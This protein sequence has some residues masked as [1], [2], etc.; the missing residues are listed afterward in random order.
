MNMFALEG[1]IFPLQQTTPDVGELSG[2]FVTLG[3]IQKDAVSR[4]LLRIAA[5]HQVKQR[6]SVR[7]AVE[8]GGLAGGYRR[9][10]HARAQGHQELQALGH[11]DHRRR[12]QPCILTGASGRDQ[13]PGKANPICGLGD[14]LEISMIHRACALVGTQIMTITVGR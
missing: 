14:L 11:R 1:H 12:H 9:R 5:G 7:Q 3:V 4:Q 2:G 13:H 10:G 6:A 8:G